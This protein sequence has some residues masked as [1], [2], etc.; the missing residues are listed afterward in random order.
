MSQRLDVHH[1]DDDASYAAEVVFASERLDYPRPAVCP[2]CDV[3]VC[4]HGTPD[5]G[6]RGSRPEL[7]AHCGI[8]GHD[9]TELHAELYG[10][11]SRFAHEHR[12]S[13]SW[14]TCHLWAARIEKFFAGRLPGG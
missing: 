9:V 10:M 3:A 8:C 12:R 11:L 1:G 4:P 14:D 5:I 7:P 6:W 13:P 2:V